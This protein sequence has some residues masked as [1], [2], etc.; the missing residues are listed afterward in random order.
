[1]TFEMFLTQ[2]ENMFNIF[3]HHGEAMSDDAK[4]RFLF[5]VIHH[6]A[7]LNTVEALKASHV[8]GNELTYSKC[9][10]HLASA[11]SQLPEVLNSRNR[12]I[13]GITTVNTNPG[14][15]SIYLEDGTVNTTGHIKGWNTLSSQDK[16]IVY[17]VRKREGV[18]FQSGGKNKDKKQTGGSDNKNTIQQLRK[19]LEKQ[20]MQIKA[21]T[22]SKT[23]VKKEPSDDEDDDASTGF[24][25]KA[26]KSTKKST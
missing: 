21:L 22:V 16:R 19:A 13:A 20:K 23:D 10:N 5:K 15:A 8:S 2:C 1:M 4:I 7:L 14:S 24:G 11:I 17:A 12:G 26:S 3:I 6:E 25:G 18:K 9:C